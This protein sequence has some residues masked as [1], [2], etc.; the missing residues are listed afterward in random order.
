M[1]RCWTCGGS[2]DP[3]EACAPVRKSYSQDVTGPPVPARF[4][5][6]CSE[7]EYGI[8]PG[9]TITKTPGGWRHVECEA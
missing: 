1:N 6:E 2:H 9:E 7:C 5:G 8:A 4:H 3:D